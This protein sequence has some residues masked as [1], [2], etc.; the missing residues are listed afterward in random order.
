MGCPGETSGLKCPRHDTGEPDGTSGAGA[1]GAAGEPPLPDMPRVTLIAAVAR[2]RVI[3][4]SNR[5]PWRLP[6]DLRRFKALTLGRPVVMGRKTFESIRDA[7]GGPLPGRRNIV[8]TRNADY[9]A[10][11]CVIVG[12]LEA[13]LAAAR[14]GD[15]VFVIGGEQ[16]YREALPIADRL[17]FTE[18]DAD[19]EGD[20]WF[21]E[22]APG[23]WRVTSREPHAPG[24]DF[25]HPF[26]FVVYERIR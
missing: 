9:T 25:A 10:P 21:P 12:S 19:F 2:N 5:L 17:Q 16:L 7:I 23:E 1:A 3:G 24:P 15:E 14:D 22:L 4:R 20:A 13:A 18:I 6:E 8:V 26:A 11:G